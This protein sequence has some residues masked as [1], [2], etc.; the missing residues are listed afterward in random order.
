MGLFFFL[1]V[2]VGGTLP[3]TS[4]PS[5]ACFPQVRGFQIYEPRHTKVYQG[6]HWPVNY[7]ECEILRAL[8]RSQR[9]SEG[10]ESADG[11]RYG[12]ACVRSGRTGFFL[13]RVQ[14]DTR[15]TK[16]SVTCAD[17]A[18]PFVLCLHSTPCMSHCSSL[19]K[20][21]QPLE[22]LASSGSI[23]SGSVSGKSCSMKSPGVFWHGSASAVGSEAVIRPF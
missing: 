14:N 6:V 20:F 22:P 8:L 10:C 3:N 17:I 16:A 15:L 12:A 5:S 2:L 1:R 9:S 19:H 21:L 7:C 13:Q 23:S 4:L 11:P 18:N